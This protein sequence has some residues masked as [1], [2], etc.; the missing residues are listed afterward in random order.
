MKFI[1]LAAVRI[2]SFPTLV[3]S[4]TML[5]GLLLIG[6]FYAFS[7]VAIET[8]AEVNSSTAAVKFQGKLYNREAFTYS[9][10]CSREIYHP[11]AVESAVRKANQE[12]QPIFAKNRSNPQDRLAVMVLFSDGFHTNTTERRI[13]QNLLH[14]SL[15]RL[16]THL[17]N[18]ALDV[19]LWV[20]NTTEYPLVRPAWLDKKE[21][22]HVHL[23]TIE[24][25]T[26]KLPCHL[27]P[28]VTWVFNKHLHDG[29]YQMGRWRM[30]FAQA[31]VRA[32]GYRYFFQFDD[33]SILLNSLNSSIV[34]QMNK[35]PAV[36]AVNQNFYQAENA[37]VVV[38][39]A[40][41]T[42]DWMKFRS[43]NAKGGFWSHVKL[44]E[45]EKG[46]D[47]KKVS[48]PPQ[49]LEWDHL[50]YRGNYILWDVNFWFRPDVQDF[51]H[52]V[53]VSNK[54]ITQRWQEQAVMNMVRL[55]FVPEKQILKLHVHL[56]HGRY[57][58]NETYRQ[59]CRS[60]GIE[61][62]YLVGKNENE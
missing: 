41:L 23:M 19:F 17:V 61:P 16:K 24:E 5:G 60:V 52:Y 40:D 45:K 39:L 26:W 13:R 12:L 33:D 31:F 3:A 7:W 35:K 47:P 57:N 29:Y 30:A 38:G 48:K 14:C 44:H 55:V 27:P 10:D 15:L 8:M 53:L 32:M 49:L 58:H 50:Y 28:R 54:D 42:R 62:L 36:L 25:D 59:W 46:K 18:I 9:Y 4:R 11:E 51:V 34:Q 1:H 22:A 56:G 6:I 37:E 2:K 21:F 43:Y 20:R